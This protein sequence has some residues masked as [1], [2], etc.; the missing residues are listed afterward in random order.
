[1]FYDQTSSR[2]AAAHRHPQQMLHRQPSRHFDAYGT[3]PNNVYIPDEQTPRYDTTTFGRT[4]GSVQGGGYGYDLPQAQAQT[5]NT[6]AFSS[7]SSFSPFPPVNGRMKSQTRAP[8]STLPNVSLGVTLS[9][10]NSLT[11]DVIE[12]DG[13][14]ANVCHKPLHWAWTFTVGD[15]QSSL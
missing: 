11:L 5:W 12:L 15:V 14:A 8:R 3:M 2:S 6:N 13:S 1:M 10:Q 4:N 7:N 9:V